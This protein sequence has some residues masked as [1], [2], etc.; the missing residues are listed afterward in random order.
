MKILIIEDD[1]PLNQAVQKVYAS[2]SFDT[3]ACYTWK[4]A[5]YELEHNSCWDLCVLDLQLPDGSGLELL[6]KIRERGS[7]PVLIISSNHNESTILRTFDLE[8]DDYIEKPFRL[9]VLMAKTKALLRR[10]GK[11]KSEIIW[12][13][14]VLIPESGTLKIR[15][16][17]IEL[18]SSELRLM[19]AFLADPNRI[20]PRT[21]LMSLLNTDSD[22]VLT[23]R[24]Y[25][26]KKKLNNPN[27]LKSVRKK[28]YRW[29]L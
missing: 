3:Q 1:I 20:F 14:F 16:K 17:K 24:I 5:D 8:A 21:W 23:S 28:G 15:D 19:E 18:S 22:Q 6:K 27:V 11:Y 4:Q 29:S 7:L 12:N 2:S 13:E 9:A 26:L 25:D 10:A